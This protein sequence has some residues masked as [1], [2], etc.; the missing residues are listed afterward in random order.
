MVSHSTSCDC[1]TLL[2]Q[3]FRSSGL[4]G[5]WPDGLELATGQ[6]PLPGTH[7]QQLQ[8]ISENEPISSLPLSTHS[9]VDFVRCTEVDH[10]SA[11]YKSIIDIDIDDMK[12]LLN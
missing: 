1:T 6:S 11:L 3:H 10:D 2:A 5:H 7:Q 4:L 8:T 9:A 12:Y